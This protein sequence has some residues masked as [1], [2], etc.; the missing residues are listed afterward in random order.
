VWN[1]VFAFVDWSDEDVSPFDQDTSS[2]CDDS[3]SISEASSEG[4]TTRI[5]FALEDDVVDHLHINDYTE[6][7][8]N[9]TWFRPH[10]FREMRER[11]RRFINVVEQRQQ[12][13]PEEEPV[14]ENDDDTTMSPI[15]TSCLRGLE[16]RTTEGGMKRSIHKREAYASVLQEQERQWMYG[17]HSPDRIAAAYQVISAKCQG[18]ALLQGVQDEHDIREYVRPVSPSTNTNTTPSSQS[19]ST[20]VDTRGTCPSTS[21][22]QSTSPS[23]PYEMEAN[24]RRIAVLEDIKIL[25][26]R[27]ASELELWQ[28]NPAA[29]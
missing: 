12:H 20:V 6:D 14:D 9:A 28:T 4:S 25:S 1:F 18:L 3:V 15:A 17:R 19:T 7:D 13:Q 27:A 10:E 29:A 8:I 11:A 21:S 2:S 23:K 22:Y 16:F 24:I 26:S 5:R